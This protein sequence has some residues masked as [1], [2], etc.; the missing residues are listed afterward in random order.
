MVT[1]ASQGSLQYVAAPTCQLSQ[2]SHHSMSAKSQFCKKICRP[3]FALKLCLCASKLQLAFGRG[4]SVVELNFA[5]G[6]SV[7]VAEA[8]GAESQHQ[9]QAR[10]H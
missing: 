9:W 7:R 3:L 2:A 5:T 1:Q 6:G 4:G 8:V 10:M